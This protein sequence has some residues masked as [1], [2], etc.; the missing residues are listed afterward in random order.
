[1]NMAPVFWKD[2]R[3]PMRRELFMTV[4]DTSCFGVC[5]VPKGGDSSHVKAGKA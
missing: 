4:D 2:V 1:M 3:L 5:K